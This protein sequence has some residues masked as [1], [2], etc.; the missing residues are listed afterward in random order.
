MANAT[1]DVYVRTTHRL[2][3]LMLGDSPPAAPLPTRTFASAATHTSPLCAPRLRALL[4]DW[5]ILHIPG[6]QRPPRQP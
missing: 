6:R 2:T 3:A 5:R 4:D 1:H